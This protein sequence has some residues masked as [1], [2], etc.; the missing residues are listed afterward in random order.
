MRMGEEFTHGHGRGGCG[1]DSRKVVDLFW[2]QNIL[3]KKHVDGLKFSCQFSSAGR[4]E[5]LVN[6]MQELHIPARLVAALI[7]TGERQEETP[8][9][10]SRGLREDERRVAA[11]LG[12]QVVEIAR[13]RLGGNALT[14]Q[15]RLPE[16]RE[17]LPESER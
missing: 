11:D 10:R 14:A 2:R 17:D 5:M 3:D 15:R 12:I 1:A 4:C 7:P 6:V 16:R 9:S 13:H 8:I